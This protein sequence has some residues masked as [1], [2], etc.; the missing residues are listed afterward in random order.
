MVK[1][2]VGCFAT[3]KVISPAVARLENNSTHLD[4]RCSC[5][6][7]S[8]KLPGSKTLKPLLWCPV[9]SAR[10]FCFSK[11][12]GEASWASKLIIA[13]ISQTNRTRHSILSTTKQRK[14][15]VSL[16]KERRVP[17]RPFLR[18]FTFAPMSSVRDP[19]RPITVFC[20]SVVYFSAVWRGGF[21]ATCHLHAVLYYRGEMMVVLRPPHAHVSGCH[22]RAVHRLSFQLLAC[23][24]S[25][26]SERFLWYL[27][28]GAY[29]RSY[30]RHQIL[31]RFSGVS[32][33]VITRQELHC[34]KI[35]S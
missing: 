5:I 28:V 14:N 21:P 16:G 17:R 27:A 11:P 2:P 23:V 10:R 30:E 18:L 12:K 32:F 6:Q 15:R 31:K 34:Y 9:P 24:S 29:W 33:A 4:C 13:S 1:S 8:S 20:S 7:A 26:F 25:L 19:G 22:H 35:T 3:A